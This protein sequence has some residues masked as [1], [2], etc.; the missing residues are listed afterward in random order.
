[1]KNMEMITNLKSPWLSEN[2][3]FHYQTKQR[4][5]CVEDVNTKY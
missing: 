2:S 3:L 5:N 4:E 1:M